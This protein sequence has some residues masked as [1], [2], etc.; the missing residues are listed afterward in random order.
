MRAPSETPIL[1]LEGLVYRYPGQDQPALCS[2]SLCLPAGRRVALLGRNG[3]GKST[4]LLHC[5]GIL[6]PESGTVRFRGQEVRYDRRSLTALR[7]AVGI[8]FQHPDDQLFSASVA[9]DISFGPLN[10]GLD[11]VDVRRRVLAAAELC[12]IADLL[13][14]PT[15]A[16]S[17]GQKAL[18]A[19]A[20]VLAMEPTILLADEV[21]TSLD[22]WIRRDVLGIFQRLVAQGKTVVL[23]THDVELARRWADLVVV[24]DAGRVVAVA[25]PDRVFADRALLAHICPDEPC[26][27]GADANGWRD[28][29]LRDG[30]RIEAETGRWTE[31]G[32]GPMTRVGVVLLGH[33]SRARE[34]NDGMYQVLEAVRRQGKRSI[35]EAGFMGMNPPTIEE[36]VAACVSQGAEVVLLIP[37]FLHLGVHVQTDLPE[38]VRELRARHPGVQFALGSPF[39][40]HPKLVEAVLARIAECEAGV[41]EANGRAAD[42]GA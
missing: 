32:L 35:V 2:A 36:G 31:R 13:D 7:R 22:P 24:M 41:V 14:R 5:N 21:T 23:A 34:A 42:L 4:L 40:F 10:L 16:L 6:K 29:G 12:G 25:S 15:H 18:V 9:Q 33:G 37:Y 19:L 1:D 38:T 30:R 17:G 3:S 28:C 8:V 11:E 27:A 39:G 20:G 26:R